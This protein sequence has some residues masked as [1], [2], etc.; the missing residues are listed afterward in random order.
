MRAEQRASHPPIHVDLRIDANV[1]LPGEVA[2]EA[3]R[4]ADVLWRLSL[5]DT[6]SPH[7]RGYHRAFC[8]RYG[9]VRVVPVSELV[10]PEAG[11][12]YPTGYR[13]PLSTRADDPVARRRSGDRER[14]IS[15][16][17]QEMFW[18]AALFG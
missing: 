15:A 18:T 11:L 6:S 3:E 12:G 7:L 9:L 2:A 8:E 4:A 13:V 5:P 17:V 1:R 14:V 10:D 16:L